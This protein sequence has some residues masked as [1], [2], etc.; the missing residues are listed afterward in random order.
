MKHMKRLFASVCVV[1]LLAALPAGASQKLYKVTYIVT[2]TGSALV[3]YRDLSGFVT[4]T[5]K[6]PFTATFKFQKGAEIA[7][8]A[9]DEA[10][11]SKAKITCEIKQPNVKTVKNSSSGQIASVLCN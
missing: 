2:G 9:T 8:D 3:S 11:S 6:L 7:V 4:K 5:V 1:I 10:L